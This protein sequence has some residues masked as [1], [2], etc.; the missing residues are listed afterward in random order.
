[1][2]KTH[3][4]LNKFQHLRERFM[5]SNFP[6]TEISGGFT[7]SPKKQV[8]LAPALRRSQKGDIP[9]CLLL[10]LPKTYVNYAAP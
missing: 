10:G 7:G 8:F 3:F 6:L 5:S 2:S 4:D 1:M 9:G